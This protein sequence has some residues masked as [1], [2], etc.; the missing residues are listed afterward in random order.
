MIFLTQEQREMLAYSPVEWNRWRRKQGKWRK[1]FIENLSQETLPYCTQGLNLRNLVCP[2]ANLKAANLSGVDLRGSQLYNSCLEKADLSGANLEKTNLSGCNLAQAN[3]RHARLSEAN[4]SRANLQGSDLSHADLRY[5]DCEGAFLG[6]EYIS[7]NKMFYFLML[8]AGILSGISG[9][10]AGSLVSGILFLFLGC[11]WAVFI[12]IHSQKEN[13][14]LFSLMVNSIFSLLVSTCLVFL[15]KGNLSLFFLT[16]IK[17]SGFAVLLCLA[18]FAIFIVLGWIIRHGIVALTIVFGFIL[19]IG[20]IFSSFGFFLILIASVAES[21]QE[22]NSP[23]SVWFPMLFS[24]LLAS[25]IS[26]SWSKAKKHLFCVQNQ[27]VFN[28]AKIYGMQGTPDAVSIQCQSLD[29]GLPNQ[30][31]P[32]SLSAQDLQEI[33]RCWTENGQNLYEFYK[34][35]TGTSLQQCPSTTKR[36]NYKQLRLLIQSAKESNG[37]QKWNDWRS[38]TPQEKIDLRRTNLSF[39]SLQ[40][41]N[42][43]HANLYQTITHP[44]RQD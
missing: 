33:S 22:K 8:F 26:L 15:Y 44:Q 6:K 30:T 7:N 21:I 41:A 27:L 20:P 40:G 35:K 14:L 19:E 39:F 42:L 4:L 18:L 9:Y 12:G 32:V 34:H 38:A 2:H 24:L 16:M 1:I 23:P 13:A 43:N 25:W 3:L 11:F 31:N 37:F 5:A 36:A 10:F 29:F 17:M 28:H